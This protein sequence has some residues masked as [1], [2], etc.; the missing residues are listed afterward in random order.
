MLPDDHL[1]NVKYKRLLSRFGE[2]G[3]SVLSA[4]DDDKIHTPKVLNEWIQLSN[5]PKK[6]KQ[7]DVV[8]P[9]NNLPISVKDTVQ[10][11]LIIHKLIEG[12]VKNQA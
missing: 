3:G 11:R 4:I 6:Y 5:G 10:Q 2:E 12:K 9:T 7:I 1:V 8:V